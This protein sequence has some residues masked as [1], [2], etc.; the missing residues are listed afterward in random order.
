MRLRNSCKWDDLRRNTI[1]RVDTSRG[2]L[3]DNVVPSCWECNTRK[4]T[5]SVERFL[6][7]RVP[8]FL[9][10]WK[11]LQTQL[12]PLG[13]IPNPTRAKPRPVMDSQGNIFPSVIAAARHHGVRPATI[14]NHLAGRASHVHG[15]TFWDAFP[16]PSSACSSAS[17]A[18]SGPTGPSGA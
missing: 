9:E 16:D 14:R 12:G 3:P 17:L 11:H 2:Y 18:R 13:A 5:L 7:D 4:S 15:I 6:G 1:D 8:E 10:K